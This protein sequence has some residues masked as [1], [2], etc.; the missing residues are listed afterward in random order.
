[1][2]AEAEAAVK[3]RAKVIAV[4]GE[5]PARKEASDVISIFPAALQVK[6]ITSRQREFIKDFVSIVCDNLQRFV[7]LIN[8]FGITGSFRE[9]LLND[10]R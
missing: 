3:A 10:A 6:R 8:L 2:V 4:K 7:G 5:M 9:P 1:M